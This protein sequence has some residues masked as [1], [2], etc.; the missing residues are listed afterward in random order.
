MF[1]GDDGWGGCLSLLLPPKLADRRGAPLRDGEEPLL[2]STAGRTME[3]VLEQPEVESTDDADV[4]GAERVAGEVDFGLKAR[5]PPV[6]DGAGCQRGC[7]TSVPLRQ[8]TACCTVPPRLVPLTADDI[9]K[10]G[11][12]E[13]MPPL[14]A[15]LRARFSSESNQSVQKDEEILLLKTQLADA[16]AVAESS[17]SYAQNLAEE[18]M[19][20]LVKV[21]QERANS[22]DYKVSCHWAVK[23]LEGGKNNH[24]AGLDEFRQRVEG[25]LQKQEEKLRKLSIEYDE[26]LPPLSSS[27][28]GMV[29]EC[30]LARGKGVAVEENSM[31]EVVNSAAAQA[32]KL[33]ELPHIA[34]LER[35]QDYPIDVIMAGDISPVMMDL[36]PVSVATVSPKIVNFWGS[37]RRLEMLRTKLGIQGSSRMYHA[38]ISR[39]YSPSSR[40]ICSSRFRPTA[41]LIGLREACGMRSYLRPLAFLFVTPRN[42]PNGD[43]YQSPGLTSWSCEYPANKG[44]VLAALQVLRIQSAVR[45]SLRKST[46]ICP[47][48]AVRGYRDVNAPLSNTAHFCQS[49]DASV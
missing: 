18:K 49:P 7:A 28:L 24:F 10:E 8:V 48:T 45:F 32:M 5:G 30:A 17:R 26:G 33:L 40:W 36:S 11:S 20:L 2:E 3:L 23:Y 41:A 12:G 46:S 27:P 21:E 44:F 13:A 19:A 38:L 29:G 4:A 6:D 34:Q 35:D 25:L 37:L 1:I 22:V 47:F 14:V 31:K 42:L 39:R 43:I 16:R 9:S 15:Q